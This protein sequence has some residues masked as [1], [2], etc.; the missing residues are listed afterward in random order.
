MWHI[1]PLFIHCWSDM[2]FASRNIINELHLLLHFDFVMKHAGD[3]FSF[4]MASANQV[5]RIFHF[6]LILNYWHSS[7]SSSSKKT[8]WP[9]PKKLTF[10]GDT[11]RKRNSRL[12]P[13]RVFNFFYW[14]PL[15]F[16]LDA[17]TGL[18]STKNG[19]H[20]MDYTYFG[21]V[22]NKDEY[23]HFS[24]FFAYSEK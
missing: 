4:G 22:L 23:A 2:A 15:I 3:L 14:S 6:F 10:T 20:L 11:V 16:I 18:H 19:Y 8:E 9:P 13:R 5:F 7:S 12:I 17:F 24:V 1:S 21:Y